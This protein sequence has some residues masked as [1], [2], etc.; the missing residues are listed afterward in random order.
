MARLLALTGVGLVAVAGSYAVGKAAMS[1]M[2]GPAT[3]GYSGPSAGAGYGGGGVNIT[4][5]GD[6]TNSAY[7]RVKDD[8]PEWYGTE[9]GIDSATQK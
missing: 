1:S 6:M 2:S 8:F 4:V 9:R 3:G 7:Q 5:Q